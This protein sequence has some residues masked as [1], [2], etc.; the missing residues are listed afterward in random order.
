M[1]EL[2]GFRKRLHEPEPLFWSAATIPEAATTSILGY[3]GVDYVMLDAEHGPF[4]LSSVRACVTALKNT[5]ASVVVRSSSADPVELAQLADLGVDGVLVP[6]IDSAEEAAAAVKAVRFPPEGKRGIGEGMLSTR[7]GFDADY[8]KH[9]NDSLAAMVILESRQGIENAAEIAAVPGLDAICVGKAD[10]SG[11]LGVPGEYRHPLVLEAVD[12]VVEC[13]LGA[14]LKVLGHS[15]PRSEDERAAGLAYC[16]TD[17]VALTEAA[18][19]AVERT[20]AAWDR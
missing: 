18:A 3:S 12:S 19:A 1:A 2:A 14:G 17:A 16:A 20:Q 15:P 9:A 8:V 13:A 6:H 4:T 11:D 10:L 5:P 7:Y